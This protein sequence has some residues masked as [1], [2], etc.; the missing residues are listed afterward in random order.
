M[1]AFSGTTMGE[2]SLCQHG[3]R[4]STCKECGGSGLCDHGRRR[5]RCKE[6]AEPHQQVQSKS[7]G[8]PRLQHGKRKHAEILSSA[9]SD[10]SKTRALA[11]EVESLKK[12]Q[13]S[14]EAQLRA[15]EAA[16]VAA[17]A[18][19]ARAIEAE[20]ELKVLRERI[21]FC[22]SCRQG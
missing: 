11:R 12:C 18:A 20:K 5:S 19:E 6:C 1:S 15:A 4:R 16:A 14:L 13:V 7:A 10:D 3:Q 2:R 21:E 9:A 17:E 8:K 22:P